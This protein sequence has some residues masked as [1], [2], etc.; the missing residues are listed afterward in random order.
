MDSAPTQPVEREVIVT[1]RDTVKVTL[2]DTV[3]LKDTVTITKTVKETVRDTVCP[4]S[5]PLAG[6]PVVLRV[7]Y[8]DL[9]SIGLGKY[10]STYYIPGDKAMNHRFFY[11]TTE[12]SK[13]G[14]ALTRAI[15]QPYQDDATKRIGGEN[16]W[17]IETIA[18]N[19]LSDRVVYISVAAIDSAG[20]QGPESQLKAVY[21]P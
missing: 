1:V 14:F 5:A 15:P 19:G 9:T 18:P 4:I 10:F 21:V 7:D 20:K 2:R 13:D 8:L 16:C 3:T 12:T 11:R 6:A 17:G